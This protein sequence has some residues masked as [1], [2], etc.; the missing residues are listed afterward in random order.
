MSELGLGWEEMDHLLA[1]AD[2][3]ISLQVTEFE[4]TCSHEMVLM[5]SRQ[6]GALE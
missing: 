2:E 5:R 4:G 1:N 6:T 3:G